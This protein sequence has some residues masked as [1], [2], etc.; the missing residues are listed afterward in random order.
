MKI[1]KYE[2]CEPFVLETTHG[3]YDDYGWGPASFYES[4]EEAR[5][6]C[7]FWA[8]K[9]GQYRVVNDGEVVY[10]TPQD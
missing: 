1:E 7:D 5:E 6:K 8:S 9:G 4:L 2:G 10:E 3:Y